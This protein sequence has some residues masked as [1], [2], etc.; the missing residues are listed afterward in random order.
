MLAKA[1]KPRFLFYGLLWVVMEDNKG[2]F[3]L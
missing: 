1:Q 2:Q 3:N